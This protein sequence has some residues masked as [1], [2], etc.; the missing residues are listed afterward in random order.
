MKAVRRLSERRSLV[1]EEKGMDGVN[2]I[3]IRH[4]LGKKEFHYNY[5]YI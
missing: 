1:E 2:M 5:P 3:S 4:I